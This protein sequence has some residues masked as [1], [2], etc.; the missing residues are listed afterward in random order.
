MEIVRQI[1]DSDLLPDKINL[2]DSLKNRKVEITISPFDG[3]DNMTK[4]NFANHTIESLL[5]ILNRD[6]SNRLTPELKKREKE[7]WAE[8]MVEKHGYKSKNN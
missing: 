5:G 4:Q 1:I 2:P 8:A 7:A 6:G 3:V